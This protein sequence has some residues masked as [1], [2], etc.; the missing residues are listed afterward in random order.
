M[1]EGVVI[2]ISTTWMRY[3]IIEHIKMTWQVIAEAK[4]PSVVVKSA[5]KNASHGNMSSKLSLILGRCSHWSLQIFRN[6][7]LTFYLP[8]MYLKLH[9]IIFLDDDVV[10][11][12]DLTGHLEIDMD[13]KVNGVIETYAAYAWAYGMYFSDPDAWRIEK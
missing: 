3:G 8:D 4:R 2:V 7:F 12:K 13:R 9:R 10:V 1:G 5:M 11:Q 6:S